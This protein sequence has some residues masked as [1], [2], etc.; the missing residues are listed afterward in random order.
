MPS[1]EFA[2]NDTIQSSTDQTPFYL[3]Y[4]HH[5]TGVIRHETIDNPHAEDKIRYLLRLQEAARD[6]INDAQQ[7]Q[8]RN[9]NRRRTNVALI[10]E[11]NWML[12]KRKEN[13]KRKLAPIVDGSFQVTKIGTN[14]ITLRFPPKS[15]AHPTI[16]ISRVQL[17]FEPRPQLVTTPPDDDAGHEYEVDRI[18]RYRKRNGKEYYYIHWKGYLA[19]D[20]TW[21]PQENIIE[22]V[23]RV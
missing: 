8:R 12:L 19:D 23:L 1:L 20:D 15:R 9:T 5:P 4:E 10:K 6:A 21:E 7:V 11:G 2:Y 18:M 3:N 17:Y 14:A 13:E 16:N 22:T